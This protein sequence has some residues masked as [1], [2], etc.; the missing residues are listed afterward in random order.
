MSLADS[1]FKAG[2]SVLRAVHGRT[3]SFGKDPI[4]ARVVEVTK[5]DER[6][7][8]DMAEATWVKVLIDRAAAEALSINRGQSFTE[9][10]GDTN[11]GTVKNYRIADILDNPARNEVEFLCRVS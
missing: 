1:M 8:V 11:L 2:A 5:D 7:T 6:Y 4:T 10:A 3:L 9:T